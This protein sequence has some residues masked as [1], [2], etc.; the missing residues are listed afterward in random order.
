MPAVSTLGTLEA[1]GRRWPTVERPW[2]P[3]SD[4]PAGVPERSCI[5]V[6]TYRLEPRETDA[7]GK[8]F[9]LSNPLLR[10]YHHQKDVP[11]GQYGRFLILIHAANWAH[12]LLGC[13]APG[14][15]RLAPRASG[16]PFDEWMVVQSKAALN[17]LRTVLTSGYDHQLQIMG[18]NDVTR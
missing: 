6:G 9:I 5:G 3:A 4:G 10:V 11:R 2:L 16:N 1:G 8:H 12:E 7:R 14:K 15:V 17:E 13:I 18:G